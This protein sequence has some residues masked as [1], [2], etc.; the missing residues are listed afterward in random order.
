MPFPLTPLSGCPQANDC[1]FR[2]LFIALSVFCS[3]VLPLS[4]SSTLA[5]HSDIMIREGNT[6]R[7][8]LSHIL[9]KVR[10]NVL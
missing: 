10:S 7:F 8:M 3:N 4:L 2:A 6:P 1:P 5:R 9:S